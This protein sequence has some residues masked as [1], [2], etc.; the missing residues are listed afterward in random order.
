MKRNHSRPKNTTFYFYKDEHFSRTNT[1]LADVTTVED[2]DLT[3]DDLREL[4]LFL[5]DIGKW[6]NFTVATRNLLEDLRLVN[7]KATVEPIKELGV[8]KYKIEIKREYQRIMITIGLAP[9]ERH[10]RTKSQSAEFELKEII[11]QVRNIPKWQMLT[12]TLSD[13]RKKIDA[14]QEVDKALK[15]NQSH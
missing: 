3:E 2:K 7:N 15:S 5:D 1:I 14:F 8:E 12:K 6:E 11:E 4:Q 10:R 9:E 13:F